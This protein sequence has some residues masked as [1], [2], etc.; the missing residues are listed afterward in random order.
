MT[1]KGPR[2]RDI[3]AYIYDAYW[4]YGVRAYDLLSHG[5]KEE[6][7]IQ[8]IWDSSRDHELPRDEIPPRCAPPH[9]RF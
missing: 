4:E 7:L 8:A 6:D 2:I 5:L 3:D 1:F 9:H